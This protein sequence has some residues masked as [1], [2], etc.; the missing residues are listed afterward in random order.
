MLRAAVFIVIMLISAGKPSAAGPRS[1]QQPGA[2]A[3]PALLQAAGHAVRIAGS[4]DGFSFTETGAILVNHADSPDILRLPNDD[5]LVVFRYQPDAGSD[6][7][8]RLAV[9]RSRDDGRTWSSPRMLSFKDSTDGNAAFGRPCLVATPGGVVRL[10]FGQ[11]SPSDGAT[12]VKSAVTR[13]GATFDVDPQV[14]VRC[15]RAAVV[16]PVAFW[17]GPGLQL[18]VTSTDAADWREAVRP[19]AVRVFSSKEGRRFKAAGV[20][21]EPVIPGDV[22][23]ERGGYRMYVMDRGGI[24]CMVSPDG[25]RWRR[26]PARCLRNGADPA[27]VQLKDGSYLM[28]YCTPLDERSARQSQLALASPSADAPQGAAPE[29]GGDLSD[30]PS[31][32]DPSG[33]LAWEP[34]TEAD[35]AGETALSGE[36]SA[37]SPKT[38]AEG[39]PDEF[40]PLPDF[41]NPLNYVEWYIDNSVPAAGENAWE[42]YASILLNKR[43]G[44]EWNVIDVLDKGG[45]KTAEPWD[46]AA[47]PDWDAAFQSADDL[48]GAFREAS[49]DPRQYGT[50]PL[51]MD[52]N[53]EFHEAAEGPDMLFEL[54]LPHLAGSRYLAKTTLAGA[55]R[56]ENGQIDPEKMKDSWTT[57]LGNV[58]HLEQGASTIEK[59]VSVA[60]R[61]LVEQHARS[62][63]EYGVFQTADDLES[64]LE[65]L[66]MH[67][68]PDPDPGSFVRFECAASLDAVQYTFSPTGDGLAIATD[69]EKTQRLGTF[70]D[71]KDLMFA[72]LLPAKT[73]NEAVE[74]FDTHYREFEDLIARGY[75][76]LREANFA[77]KEEQRAMSNPIT[78]TIMPCLSRACYLQTRAEASRRATQLSYGVHL[79]KARNGRWPASLDE[80]PAEHRD[81]VRADP[82]TNE[83]LRY[84]ADSNGFTIYTAGENGID[85]GGI[86]SPAGGTTKDSNSD[87]YVFWPPQK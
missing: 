46:P 2:P 75:P 69:P 17:R 61:A 65:T 66:Q 22:L 73:V 50:P 60:E 9:V 3:E 83:D 87:D 25:L 12:V 1:Q 62:A 59:L 34:F 30:G 24:R 35:V 8:V 44:P 29:G 52:E 27:V 26:H 7:R 20:M 54:L 19:P 55:W 39:V 48:L 78:K 4:H 11:A 45:W 16:S 63:L 28:L 77:K 15:E 53:G 6:S 74:L 14:Q 31:G 37:G 13:D 32:G 49:A 68:V 85:D 86:H 81:F 23:S 84:R 33:D 76:A 67:D 51:R 71:K 72:T 10:Y 64:A 42:S 82:F 57:V 79:F 47:H 21:R 43:E 36:E 80:L 38:S 5:L 18:L 70:I 56:L 40:P 58:Q 41:Q